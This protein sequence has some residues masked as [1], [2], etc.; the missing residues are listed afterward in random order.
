MIRIKN[1]VAV[2]AMT[3][4]AGLPSVQI[5]DLYSQRNKLGPEQQ[6]RV[7]HPTRSA[8]TFLWISGMIPACSPQTH[9]CGIDGTQQRLVTAEGQPATTRGF[10]R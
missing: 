1:A 7:P 5:K 8:L 3:F 10:C 6:E 9:V 4:A 2:L